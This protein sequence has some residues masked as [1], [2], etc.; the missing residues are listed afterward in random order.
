MHNEWGANQ[1]QGW[2]YLRS[3]L[4]VN[5]QF[6]KASTIKIKIKDES[7]ILSIPALQSTNVYHKESG[8][9]HSVSLTL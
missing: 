4:H 9:A 5:V 1:I 8:T 3:H 6:I 7:Q 2:L